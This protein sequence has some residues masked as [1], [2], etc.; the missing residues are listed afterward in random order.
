VNATQVRVLILILCLFTIDGLDMQLLG[1]TVMALASD[2]TLPLTAFAT[3]MAAGHAG[4]AVGTSIGGLLG[5]RFG[6][7]PIIVAGTLLFGVLSLATI[8]ATR[9]EHMVALRFAAGLGLGG[10]LPPALALLTEFMPARRGGTAVALALVCQPLGI[11][12]AGVLAGALLPSVG[13]QG[14]FLIAGAV[15]TAAAIVLLVALPES[16]NYCSSVLTHRRVGANHPGKATYNRATVG[17]LLSGS[18]GRKSVSLF[19][20]FFGAYFSMSMVLSWLPALLAKQGFT[21]A[22]SG[23]ALSVWS[24]SGIVGGVLA[25]LLTSRFA[26]AQIARLYMVSA[27]VALCTIA[28]MLPAAANVHGTGVIALYGLIACGGC[29]L[30]GTITSLYAHGST[31]LP[32]LI[33]AS[34]IGLAATSGRVGAIVGAYCGATV[35]DLT[36]ANGYFFATASIVALALVLFCVGTLAG[37]RHQQLPSSS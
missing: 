24:A 19:A 6:R 23:T 20:T 13:W 33:R 9:P 21:V 22:I 15:P 11:T 32:S 29:T 7:K 34:A 35:L 1:V 5:D 3:A 17:L 31:A 27:I 2:W 26:T 37:D 28:A 16:P 8:F 36:G 25:G 12:L 14:M 4:A 18:N 10:C 30:S